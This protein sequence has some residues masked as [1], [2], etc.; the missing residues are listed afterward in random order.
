MQR[1]DFIVVE[2]NSRGRELDYRTLYLSTDKQVADAQES[3]SREFYEVDVD[4][5]QF[6]VPVTVLTVRDGKVIGMT[7]PL[8]KAVLMQEVG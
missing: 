2:W 4:G 8:A 7:L 1:Y 3:I 6:G 5:N